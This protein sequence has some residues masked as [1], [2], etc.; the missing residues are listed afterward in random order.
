LVT[1]RSSEIAPP[2]D[3]WRDAAA[4][5]AQDGFLSRIDILKREEADDHRARME[6]V[7]A[8][9]GSLH[10]KNKIHTILRSPYELATHPL[11][12]DIVRALIGPDILIYNVFYIV[13]EAGSLSHVSWHQDLTYWGFDRDNLVSMW[14]ALSPATPESGCMRM[15]PGS[16]VRGPLEHSPTDDVT[17]ILTQGQ[18]VSGVVEQHGVMCALQPG[19]ASFHHGWTLHS[20][21][22]NTSADRRIGLSV[23]YLA[24][25]MCQ[26]K[27]D[28][29]SA[30]LVL[31]EDQFGH[32]QA[33]MPAQTD[34]EP[35][36]VERH[37]VLDR[38]HLEIVGTE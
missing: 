10:Y 30:M 2:H 19:Q 9:I 29:D 17:N 32:F 1:G 3:E 15:V 18:A 8:Q 31:G 16:H 35:D 26:T 36:A 13:K 22:P 12:L 28:R 5:Y 33:D 38:R 23:N 14:L 34:L 20:S 7:E 6:A 24:P 37:G 4:R 21:R 27:H 25:S 11:V